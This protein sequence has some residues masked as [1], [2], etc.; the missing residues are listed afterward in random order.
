[1]ACRSWKR[2]LDEN[3]DPEL[4]MERAINTYRKKGYSEEWNHTS[5]LKQ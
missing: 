4:A 5:D 2:T 3:A 1:L